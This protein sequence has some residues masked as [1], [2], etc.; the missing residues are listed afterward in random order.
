[1]TATTGARTARAA[2]PA[3]LAAVHDRSPLAF[4]WYRLNQLILGT[5]LAAFFGIRVTGRRNIPA[6]GALLLVSNHLSHL[7][8]VALGAF[9]SR[10]MNYIARST[11]FFP[12]LSWMIRSLGAF[13]IQRDGLGASGIKETLRRL[14]RGGVVVLFPEG[15]RSRDGELGELKQGVATLAGRARVPILPAAMAGVREAW[16]RSSPFPIRH[17]IRLHYGPAITS[18]QAA[19]LD[20]AALTALIRERV[21]DAQAVA[22]A[23]LARDVG[24]S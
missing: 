23:G 13:P 6:T 21:L 15:T 11:L 14:K 20:P 1:M 22:R 19:G 7:D 8:V 9:A 5:I 24:P 16:P 12:P 2:K 10:P 3:P 4:A 17:A 18:D